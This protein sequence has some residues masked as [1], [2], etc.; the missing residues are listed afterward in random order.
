MEQPIY[1][2][3]SQLLHYWPSLMVA[4]AL[5][6][7]LLVGPIPALVLLVPGLAAALAMPWR[8]AVHDRGIALWFAFG[9]Y[10]YLAKEQVSVRVGHG[11]TVLLPR[12]ADRFGYPLTNGLVERR[13]MV[14]RA[15][16]A[17]H[18]FDL[19]T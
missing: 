11:S 9:K 5:V 4:G 1:V 7:Y 17:E 2:G 14:L 8:F 18:G 15:V 19:A 10:R 16:L 12:R 6:G 13:R 3:Q